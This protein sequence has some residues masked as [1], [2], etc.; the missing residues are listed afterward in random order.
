MEFKREREREEK[1]EKKKEKRKAKQN[2]TRDTENK[3]VRV[4]G[5]SSTGKVPLSQA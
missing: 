3:K 5:D 1:K 4:W 2:K